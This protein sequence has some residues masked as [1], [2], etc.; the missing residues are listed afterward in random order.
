MSKEKISHREYI[1]EGDLTPEYWDTVVSH[2]G[3][4]GIKINQLMASTS[5]EQVGS[6]A[7][8]ETDSL[9]NRN[10]FKNFAAMSAGKHTSIIAGRAWSTLTELYDHKINSEYY[11]QYDWYKKERYIDLPLV[12]T[13]VKEDK[14]PLWSEKSFADLELEGLVKLLEMANEAQYRGDRRELY[15]ILGRHAGPKALLFLNDLVQHKLQKL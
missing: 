10:D 2:L 8:F 1:I 9:L 14:P 4:A 15:R 7:E 3:H 11:E 5:S 6:D 12:F 13:T